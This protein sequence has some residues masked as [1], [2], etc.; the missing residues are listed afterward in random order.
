MIFEK[1]IEIVTAAETTDL[2]NL[3]SLD[4]T[5]QKQL[6]DT[7]QNRVHANLEK[8]L[9]NMNWRSPHIFTQER[10]DEVDI[11][12][13]FSSKDGD[14][15]VIIELDKWRA[16]QIAKK[17]VSRFA[18]TLELPLIYIALCYGGTKNMN[19]SECEK[20]FSYCKRICDS[21]T[22]CNLGTPKQFYGH[23]LR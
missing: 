16:D 19:K 2:Q 23:I 22:R 12:G 4:Q 9:P 15:A 20:Y 17:F 13:T 5:S 3:E 14:G 7:F 18:L 11:Y 8:I 1:I 6:I 10:R 21:F